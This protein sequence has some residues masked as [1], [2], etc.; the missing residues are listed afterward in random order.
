MARKPSGWHAENIKAEL[1]KRFGTLACFADH[2]GLGRTAISD[3]FVAHRSSARVELLVAAAIGVP[4]QELW[5]DRWTPDG[6]KIARK[7]PCAVA[8]EANAA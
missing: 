3:V 4:V 8:G 5:P 6:L 7:Q 1:R 2:I